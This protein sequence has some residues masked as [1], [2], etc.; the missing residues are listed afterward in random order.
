[1]TR[2]GRRVLSL[3]AAVV[4][5]LVLLTLGWIGVAVHATR[6]AHRLDSE[7]GHRSDEHQE[8]LARMREL[9][10]RI[11]ELREFAAKP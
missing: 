6:T 11:K 8:I 2:V 9:M 5:W 10:E 4:V 3:G 1:M 7:M